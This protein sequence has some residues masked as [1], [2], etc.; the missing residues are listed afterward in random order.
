M[1][2]DPEGRCGKWIAVML[3][4]DLEIRP[5]K[6][7]K[8]QCLAK[9][10]AESNLHALDINFIVA[11]FEEQVVDSF[12]QVSQLFTSSPWYSDIVHVL[13]HLN[14]PPDVSKSKGR[15]LKLKALKYCILDNA[16]YWK[17]PRGVLLNCLV[18]SEAKEVMNDFNKCDCG[19]HRFWKTT[20]HK[21]LRANFYWLSLFSNV[22]KIVM[23]CH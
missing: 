4:Y 10:M 16:L 15:S 5:T 12:P 6:L 7:V 18:E 11:L 21:I 3:E 13:Q 9:L 17:D 1:Q 2:N 22:Y 23:N 19:G 8:G 14:P 20:A